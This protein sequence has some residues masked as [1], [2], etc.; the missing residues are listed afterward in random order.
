MGLYGVVPESANRWLG[1]S[2]E[3]G[4][5]AKGKTGGAVVEEKSDVPTNPPKGRRRCQ[6]QWLSRSAMFLVRWWLGRSRINV[7]M[8]Q[9]LLLRS[10]WSWAECLERWEAPQKAKQPVR[11]RKSQ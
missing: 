11:L 6:R 5:S 10:V 4:G 3:G 2:G 7:G 1:K 9:K 8:R